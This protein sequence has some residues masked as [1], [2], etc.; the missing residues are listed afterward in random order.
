MHEMFP[1]CAE[2]HLSARLWETSA[3]HSSH[4]PSQGHR[5][6]RGLLTEECRLRN[7]DNGVRRGHQR[8]TGRK[9]PP[10]R[11]SGTA[12]ANDFRA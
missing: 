12:D 4:G 5:E 3:R 9:E 11:D 2:K 7:G 6:Q 8:D 1:R 10:G